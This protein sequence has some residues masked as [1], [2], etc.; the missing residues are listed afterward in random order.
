[1]NIEKIIVN[2]AVLKKFALK[3]IKAKNSFLYK[4]VVLNNAKKNQANLPI[5]NVRV[6]NENRSFG[7]QKMLCNAPNSSLYFR[8]N[9]DVLACCR[10]VKDILGNIQKNTVAEI[11]R[12]SSREKLINKIANND[13]NDGCD[14]CKNSIKNGVYSASLSNLYD[15]PFQAENDFPTDITFE[16]SNKCNLECIMCNGDFSSSIRKNREQIA[17]LPYV[18]PSNFLEQLKP[19]LEKT[20]IIRLQG[21]EPFLIPDYLDIIEYVIQKNPRCKIYIQTNGTILNERVRRLINNPLIYISISCD[22]FVK[23]TYE[24]IRKNASFE[25]FNK[26][27]DE[28]IFFSKKFENQLNIN[29]CLMTENID[30]IQDVFDIVAHKNINLNVLYVEIPYNLNILNLSI[31]VL[32]D[33][34]KKITLKKVNNK[35]EHEHKKCKNYIEDAI[36][37]KVQKNNEIDELVNSNSLEELIGQVTSK[38]NIY[39]LDSKDVFIIQEEFNRHT[40]K[41]PH[42]IKNALAGLLLDMQIFDRRIEVDKIPSIQKRQKTFEL[43]HINIEILL[44]NNSK[45]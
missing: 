36:H 2:N 3:L 12:S 34:L 44:R 10:N 45:K 22:S 11:W 21:G 19:F 35:F 1:M 40:I 25:S 30:E 43:F 29:Y 26:N 6:Y 42:V 31:S 7:Y 28:F 27:L 37:K 8:T 16:I 33:T 4:N 15:T 41:N 32:E 20:K 18:Y 14:F 5:E 39:K 13:L 38:L 9:G 24:K 17:A 23:E